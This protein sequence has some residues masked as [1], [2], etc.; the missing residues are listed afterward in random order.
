MLVKTELIL[1]FVVEHRDRYGRRMDPTTAFIQRHTLDAVATC[2]VAELRQVLDGDGGEAGRH[3]LAVQSADGVEVA[4]VG[5]GQLG[6]EQ[7][8]IVAALA[9][10]YLDNHRIFLHVTCSCRSGIMDPRQC[11][12]RSSMREGVGIAMS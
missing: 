3:D 11:G 2:L 12:A 5:L 6:G 9:C 7:G 4:D 10:A 1:L 8:G